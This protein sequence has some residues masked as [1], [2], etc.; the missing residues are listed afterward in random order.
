MAAHELWLYS[1]QNIAYP[2]EIPYLTSKKSSCPTL[3][4][5]LLLYIHGWKP[6]VE[7][8]TKNPWCTNH[9]TCK[10][11]LP[12]TSKTYPHRHDSDGKSQVMLEQVTP[13]QRYGRC[14]GYSRFTSNWRSYFISVSHATSLL[15]NCTQLRIHHLFP[16]E[17][18]WTFYDN[19]SRFHWSTFCQGR[20]RC[21]EKSLYLPIYL[22]FEKGSQYWSCTRPY[23]WIFLVIIWKIFLLKIT[24]VKDAVW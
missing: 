9:G 18:V 2:K 23:K 22:C 20:K 21:R 5:Q 12:S 1:V 3:V 6:T 17:A 19:G 15:E 14:F 10:I 13:S 7:M 8:R 16:S 11:S 4:K 24:I